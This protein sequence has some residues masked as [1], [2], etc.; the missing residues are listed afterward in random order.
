MAGQLMLGIDIG[1][2]GT[3]TVLANTN[4]KVVARATAEYPLSRPQP[5]WA[6]QDA[7]DW[8]QATC[9]TIRQVL[10]TSGI[11]AENIA[12]VGL[13]GQMHGSVFLA[14]DGSV[15]R[16]PLLWC[17]VRTAAEC[18][19]ITQAIGREQLIAATCNPA[20][21]GFTAPK[22][23]W[24]RNHEPANYARLAH[25]LLPKDYVRYRLT[26]AMVTDV[27]DAAGT[28]LFDVAARR[29]SDVV[30][31]ALGI[32]PAILPPVVESPAVC[33]S[34]SRVAAQLTGLREGTPV[35]GGGADNTC[36][37]VGAGIVREG[38]F[39]SSIG[40]SGVIVAHTDS[41]RQDAQA[42]IHT[43]NHSVPGQWYLMGVMLSAGLSLRWFRDEFARAEQQVAHDTGI[44][45]YDLL[46]REA[47]Q[48]PPGSRGVV[49]L[50]YLNG[51]RTPHADANARGVFFG[52]SGAH[53]R[54]DVVR[55]IMEGVT[56]GLRDSVEIMRA[57][58]LTIKQLRA[59]GGGAKSPLWRQ[60][61]AD[62]FQA[63]VATLEVDEGPAFGAALLAGV[64]AGLFS[65]VQ[66]AADATVKVGEITEP[67]PGHKARYEDNYAVFRNL[68]PA[69]RDS[70][71]AATALSS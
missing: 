17:D 21:E 43:F 20:L 58:G 59:I 22:V 44:D 8:F 38:R 66:E 69:L 39:L 67:I 55:S 6:E 50:P 25:L 62:I 64:G 32:D 35:V 7:E 12:G 19:Q 9:L 56:F 16:P 45:A 41:V 14:A 3:K 40:S 47:A 51:E 48:S 23:V 31:Q 36:G 37:A 18:R 61:Q 34:I 29:W 5:G 63:E 42:R 70:F 4:G 52:L 24:L 68:Y 11:D 49:F 57:M 53:H 54:A 2:S 65:S 60:M 10:A 28:L 33:G 27:S 46:S 13:S 30:L 26:G 1:T 71:A 15:I